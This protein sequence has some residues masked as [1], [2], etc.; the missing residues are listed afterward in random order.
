M[1]EAWHLKRPFWLHV[2]LFRALSGGILLTLGSCKKWHVKLPV[3]LD[4]AYLQIVMGRKNQI[5][6]LVLQVCS[7]LNI[8]IGSNLSCTFTKTLP[9]RFSHCCYVNP[10]LKGH[11]AKDGEDRKARDKAGGTVQQAQGKRIP[12]IRKTTLSL[13]K[14]AEISCLVFYCP[15]L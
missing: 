3:N 4:K 10:Q 14:K 7:F 1:Y 5:T 13:K 12:V 15:Y 6:V 11:E 8:F 2:C 9:T